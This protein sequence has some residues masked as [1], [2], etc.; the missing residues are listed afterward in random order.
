MDFDALRHVKPACRAV[1]AYTLAAQRAPI[2]VNQNENPFDLPAEIKER[3]LRA[4]AARDWARYPDFDPV[5]LLASL[6]SFAGWRSDGVLAGNGSNEL[7]EATLLV[8]VGAG[9]RVVIP[10]PTFTLYGLMTTLLGG[11]AVPVPLASDLS[12]DVESLLAARRA[13]QAP[14]TIVCSPNNPTGGVLAAEQVARLCA[15]ADGLV[16]IDEAYHEFSGRTVVPLLHAHPNLIVLRTFS[17][18]MGMA[19]LRVGYLLA[20][21]ELVREINKARLPYNVNFF[22][23]LAALAALEAQDVL[24][25]RVALL[26]SERARL[27]AGLTGVP[28]VARV[29]PSEANFLLLELARAR[30]R[31]V[32][33]ALHQRGILVRDVS[34][35]PRLASC[36]RVSVGTP[37]END[38]LLAAL[39]PALE[40]A[41]AEPALASGRI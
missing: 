38:A 9:T 21:P 34:G 31:A 41:L 35:Y 20:A 16:V 22:S 10:E 23:Q 14:V 32:F 37:A 6:A 24:A 4:A 12:Y 2:K 8:S 13:T 1:G 18:A 27:H 5:E 11:Q 39:A 30:P 25:A 36:L 26:R 29:Y 17:K 3:V 28:G 15:D 40:A 33:E 19:G 7:I